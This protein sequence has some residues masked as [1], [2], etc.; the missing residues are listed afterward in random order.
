MKRERLPFSR[1]YTWLLRTLVALLAVF[2]RAGLDWVS[3]S[4]IAAVAISI[5]LGFLA[6]R[7]PPKPDE[8]EKVIFPKQ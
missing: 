1:T 6:D 8:L 2:W 5:A 4:T 3:L 7:H